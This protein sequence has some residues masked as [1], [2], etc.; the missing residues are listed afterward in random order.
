MSALFATIASCRRRSTDD[1]PETPPRPVV[2]KFVAPSADSNVLTAPYTSTPK[3]AAVIASR[4]IFACASFFVLFSTTPATTTSSSNARHPFNT[5]AA[6]LGRRDAQS[7]TRITGA[8]SHFAISPVLPRSSPSTP[9]KSPSAPST[10]ATSAS[11]DARR[12]LPRLYSLESIHPSR[13]YD[14]RP[15]AASCSSGSVRS[16][17]TLKPWTRRPR[18]RSA[19]MTPTA[20]VVFPTP[21]WVPAKT[22][23]FIV[24]GAAPIRLDPA[25]VLARRRSRPS[26]VG[27]R[28]RLRTRHR[29]RDRVKKRASRSA[30]RDV[31]FP[32]GESRSARAGR[33]AR[34]RRQIKLSPRVRVRSISPTP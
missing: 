30:A 23:T 19:A 5:A 28:R 7:S 26:R 31:A 13:L 3:S 6:L 27:S 33:G 17:P 21:A 25:S 1:A 34:A 9:S 22:M 24:P 2:K 20:T 32:P 15:V 29:P 11:M 16:G 4:M 8:P 12:T 18:W 14:G 10:I